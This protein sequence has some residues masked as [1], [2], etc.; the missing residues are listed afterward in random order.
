MNI[1]ITIYHHKLPISPDRQNNKTKVAAGNN[2]SKLLG[3][4]KRDLSFSGIC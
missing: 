1:G 3:H 4:L 2:Q